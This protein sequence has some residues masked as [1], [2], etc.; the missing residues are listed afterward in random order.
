MNT[1]ACTLS[2]GKWRSRSSKNVWNWSLVACVCATGNPGIGKSTSIPFLIRLILK[3][4][5]PCTVVY[6]IR[7]DVDWY[8]Q[9]TSTGDGMYHT[10][11]LPQA[12]PP[13]QIPSLRDE[14][15]F[16]IV[17]S[18]DGT[19]GSCNP[20]RSVKACVLL[21][22][23]L[24]SKHW[25][26]NNF[27][28]SHRGNDG[29]EFRYNFVWSWEDLKSARQFI[30]P[31]LTEDKMIDRYRWFGGIPRYVFADELETLFLAQHDGV[32]GMTS[33]QAVQIIR[34]QIK[35]V[36][37][38]AKSKPSSQVLGYWSEPPSNNPTVDII[39]D[40]VRDQVAVK[41][42]N[43]K[44][45]LVSFNPVLFE[46]VVRHYLQGKRKYE[47]KLVPPKGIASVDV[48]TEYQELGDFGTVRLVSDPVE[49]VWKKEDKTLFHSV[50]TRHPLF[51]MIC[52]DGDTYHAIQATTGETHSCVLKHLR[53]LMARLE[54]TD[55][56]TLS[57]WYAVPLDK[58]KKFDVN[59]RGPN[60]C[61]PSSCSVW[62][63]GIPDPSQESN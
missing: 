47:C 14:N 9:F 21:I 3:R 6:Q 11:V 12:I 37:N 41:A 50:N 56:E 52:K 28:K 63:F 4:P 62:I 57:L 29:G 10:E 32:S 58:L 30:S 23:S 5:K 27:I 60:E 17:D 45:S 43:Y 22:T 39:S 31:W 53:E 40:S 61:T 24:D 38:S 16:L 36:D 55:K 48:L 1:R 33:D 20:S 49:A 35:L 51:D 2:S 18:G 44:W 7:G 26:G 46:S 59:P 54:L 34:G 8:Y 19:T 13:Q 25:G 42:A 15:N